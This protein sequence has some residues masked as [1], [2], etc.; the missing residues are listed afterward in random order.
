MNQHKHGSHLCY[1]PSCGSQIEVEEY[2]KCNE[3]DCENCGDKMRAV[4]TGEYRLSGEDPSMGAAII[5]LIALTGMLV[6]AAS[7]KV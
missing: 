6:W 7:R 1:C 3:L 2:Q 4:E 5:G